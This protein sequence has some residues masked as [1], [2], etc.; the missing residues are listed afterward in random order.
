[1]PHMSY[2]ILMGNCIEQYEFL[3]VFCYSLSLS[4]SPSISFSHT[5]THS[6]QNL[7]S[8]HFPL[9]SL[10]F[11]LTILLDQVLIIC[12]A[13]SLNNTSGQWLAILPDQGTSYMDSI[14]CAT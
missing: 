13:D 3:K 1:M 5:H 11:M 2:N 10:T 7:T 6:S 9:F 14:F 8:K 4:L 12:I